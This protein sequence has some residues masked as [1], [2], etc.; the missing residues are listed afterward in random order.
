M[1]IKVEGKGEGLSNLML[2]G[3]GLALDVAVG[4]A[5]TQDRS[6]D[7]DEGGIRDGGCGDSDKREGHE[8]NCDHQDVRDGGNLHRVYLALQTGLHDGNFGA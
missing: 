4:Q 2:T 5:V 3:L 6:D 7:Q 1:E 8:G